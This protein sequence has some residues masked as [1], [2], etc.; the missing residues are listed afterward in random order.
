MLRIAHIIN[1]VS[2]KPPS[3]LVVAQPI[4]F[5]SMRAARQ[6]ALQNE[7]IAVDLFAVGYAEDTAVAPADFIWLPPLERSVLDVADFQQARKLPLLSD[8]LGRLYANSDADLFIYTNVDIGLQPHFYTAVAHLWRSGH[9]AFVINRRTIPADFTRPSQLPLMWAEIGKP[10]RG[11]DC[12]VFPRALLPNFELGSVCIGATRVGLALLSNLVAY[13]R[14][15]KEVKDA[16][17]TF[18]IGDERQWLNP[19]FVDYDK[20]NTQELLQILTTLEAQQGEFERE[21]I[22][23]S[24]LWRTRTFGAFYDFWARHVYLPPRLSNMLNRLLRD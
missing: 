23:G 1:P 15:F 6:F 18:H 16:H 22:P 20:H 3:D 13:G 12:F 9:E 17:L 11:W 14:A 4:T 5:E 7:D 19:A 24:Y 10:H 21:S 2:A 8:I